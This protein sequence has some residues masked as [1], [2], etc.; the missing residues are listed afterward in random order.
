MAIVEELK[1][2]GGGTGSTIE[3]AI[4]SGDFS[5]GGVFLITMTEQPHEHED[6]FNLEL[7]KTWNEIHDAM[8]S[9]KNCIVV[10]SPNSSSENYVTSQ[11]LNLNDFSS[12]ET[13]YPEP[14]AVAFRTEN[15]SFLEFTATS[16]DSPLLYRVEI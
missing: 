12:A 7:D 2:I 5:G 15:N 13:E 16:S 6:S 10:G 11:I 14:Y 4:A 9:G 1:K 3:E 8:L